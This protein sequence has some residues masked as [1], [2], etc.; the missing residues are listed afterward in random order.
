MGN[1]SKTIGEG[2]RQVF[3]AF[4]RR[5]MGWNLIDAFARLEEREEETRHVDEMEELDHHSPR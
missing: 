3:S 2:L 4:I 5:P 1:Q